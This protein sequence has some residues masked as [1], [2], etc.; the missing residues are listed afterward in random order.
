MG[1]WGYHISDIIFLFITTLHSQSNASI[2]YWIFC[3]NELHEDVN[4][5][6]NNTRKEAL[7]EMDE[8]RGRTEQEAG[9]IIL[10]EW[11][12]KLWVER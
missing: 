3:R 10:M 7:R 2:L 1:E 8:V 5:E 9:K 6:I 12:T 11:I 4:T